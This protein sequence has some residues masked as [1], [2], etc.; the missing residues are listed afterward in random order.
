MELTREQQIAIHSH[1]RNLIVVA[2]AGSGKTLVLVERY[3]ALLDEHPDWPL[4][5]LV[6]ITFTK[7]AAQEMRDR[8]RQRLEERLR[9]HRGSLQAARWQERLASMD[10]AR[11]D[12]IHGLC[13]TLL[14]ANAAE[15]GIDPDFAV[16]DE[17]DARILLETILDEL[18]PTLAAEND[19]A[20]ALLAEYGVRAVRDT[21]V[22]LIA[23]DIHQTADNLFDRWQLHWTEQ[24]A[25]Q[26]EAALQDILS[27]LSWQ[28]AKGWPAGEDLIR[29]GWE[30]CLTWLEVLRTR[31]DFEVRY[32]AFQDIAHIKLSAGSA[33]VWG[34]EAERDEAKEILSFIR[35]TAK[36]VIASIG[37]RPDDQD[38]RAAELL[39]LWA[40]L[41]RRAQAAY[42]E[43]K[44]QQA[45]LDFDDLET[46]TRD[47][48]YRF[49]HVRARYLGAEFKHVLVDEFQD[50]NAAQWDIVRALAEPTNP[51]CLF[52]VGDDKQSIY[53]FR[54]ADVSVFDRVRRQIL[55]VGGVDV[56]LVRSFRSHRRLVECFNYIFASVLV[57]DTGSPDYE[58]ELGVPLQAAREDAPCDA[59]ALELLLLDQSLLD[60]RDKTERC[61]RWEANE[62][63]QR[64]RFIVEA[65]CRPV[66]DKQAGHVRA[67]QYG[68]IALLFQSTASITLYEDVFKSARLPFVTIA[69]RGYYSRQEVWDL[70]NLLK[71]LH[72][73]ADNLALAAILR[74]PL[75]SLS[76]DALLALRLSR[77]DGGQRL[78]LWDAL[79]DPSVVP[80]DERTLATFARDCLYDLRAMAG[81]VT[82]SELLREALIRTGYLATLTGLPDGARRRGN[83]EK[84]L[85]KAQTTGKV[86]LSAFSQY[87]R[88]LSAREVREGE[89]RV[90]DENAV[91]LMTVHAS[92]G[93]EFPIVVLVDASW[94][95]GGGR[96]HP[97]I[98]DPE[99]GL[100]CKVYDT[101]EDKLVDTYSYRQ[102]KRL[103]NLRET[104]EHRR[105]LYVA[106]TRAQDYLLVSGQIWRDKQ[107]SPRTE[108]WLDWLWDALNLHDVELQPSTTRVTYEW[109]PVSI[110]YPQQP[111]DDASESNEWE[112]APAWDSQ[113]VQDGQ[114]L[115]GEILK[116]RLLDEVAYERDAPAR[117]LTA[118]QLA[119]LGSA[120]YSP[121]YRQRFLR[122]IRHGGPATIQQAALPK[123]RVSQRILGEIVHRALRWGYFPTP[124]DDL[125]GILESYAWEQGIVDKG[126]RAHAVQ[127]ART[128][129][130][131]AKQ[132]DVYQWMSNAVQIFRELPFVYKTDK[133][134]I[135]GVL[136]VLFQ[137][138]DGSWTV[139]D[140]KTSRVEGYSGDPQLIVDHARRYHLQVGVYAAAAREQL[141]GITPNVYIHYIRYWQTVHVPEHEWRH[142]LATLED[143]IGQLMQPDDSAASFSSPLT[144]G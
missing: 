139:L 49:P 143:Q 113:P 14:R 78:G 82:I 95:K 6:A 10:S 54:G 90:D 140:Y 87:L 35:D 127:E 52:L 106:A 119:D 99:F 68:D 101:D 2:G 81:R 76:D 58:V 8:V 121:E 21:L 128:L 51:G 123:H 13:A 103:N 142:A 86:T 79:R 53:Q 130:Q 131:R 77:D 110:L 18:L 73:P 124:D 1:R 105:L 31:H 26:V 135:H 80:A 92:K 43:A 83:V 27:A 4:N 133:R 125:Q 112:I 69:G 30:T 34:G 84:L 96:T 66:Y 36:E 16:L 109:G 39:P 63:A 12:T 3:L 71:A 98:H 93:L 70:I 25:R 29:S 56:A 60:G 64:L 47:L 41:I 9:Q 88:D 37:P 107:G 40:R 59:P 134:T 42:R 74:S 55:D 15:A 17:V 46:L 50:T 108:G 48:L 24:A 89:A 118:T 91:T 136:D 104:A 129:L 138:P 122:S 97:V 23:L 144:E 117:H 141:G 33:K 115:P 67:A 7:K 72:N 111:S 19:P 65:E 57:K 94:E 5:A 100:A 114:L 22:D 75:F 85:D 20:L 102:A 38:R 132:S 45:A 62:L 116:P 126:Q 32:Q 11:I 120:A 61:R 28:P 44:R 137:N